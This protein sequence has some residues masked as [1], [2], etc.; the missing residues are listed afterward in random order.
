MRLD[1]SLLAPL[2]FNGRGRGGRS[3]S[4]DNFL[5]AGAISVVENGDGLGTRGD[6]SRLSP[7]S[8]QATDEKSCSVCKASP[9]VP[10]V[11]WLNAESAG[12]WLDSFNERAA[13]LQY[14]A[15]FSR[16]IAE[17]LAAEQSLRALSEAAE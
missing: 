3:I 8:P 12:R 13:I 10:R 1:Y 14:E 9:H 7:V 5:S 11:P 16:G 4:N 15:G 6:V 2:I 17:T